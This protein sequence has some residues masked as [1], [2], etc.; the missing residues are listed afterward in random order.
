MVTAAALLVLVQVV[1]IST[2][3]SRLELIKV[4]LAVGAGTGAALTLVLA[5]RR[6]WSTEH[7]ATERRLT[8][9][10]V[11][12]VEQLGSEQAA[13]RHGGLYAL[14]RVAQDNPDHRQTVVDVICAYLRGPYTPPSD[15]KIGPRL[16]VQRP[17]LRSPEKRVRALTRRGTTNP[18]HPT[19]EENHG[20][21]E[22]EVRLTA[23]RILTR[24]LRPHD[25]HGSRLATYWPAINL[26]LTRATLTGFDLRACKLSTAGFNGAQF[27]GHAWFDNTQFTGHAEFEGAHFTGTA[28]FNGTRFANRAWFEGAQFADTAEFKDAQFSDDAWFDSAHFTGRTEFE[29]AQFTGEAQFNRA[30]FA[31]TANFNNVQF[32]SITGFIE[33]KF[34]SQA[35]FDYTKFTELPG[36]EV[37]S[38]DGVYFA[39]GTPEPLKRYCRQELNDAP[40]LVN[41]DE[42]KQL[43]DR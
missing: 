43:E 6:Q 27:T 25:E 22:R 1:D 3:N 28:E 13:V 33:S 18:P 42:P 7:D 40:S 39:Q 38:F 19:P 10:Y 29:G 15:R 32:N 17:L 16:G 14:E 35:C 9:L 37:P 2:P 41:E 5:R 4:A 26:E 21:Q 23:Q 8:D 34:A 30:E 12:A 31:S 36:S 11:K 24:H 20:L